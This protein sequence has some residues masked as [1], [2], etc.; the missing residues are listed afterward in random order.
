MHLNKRDLGDPRTQ[1]VL[2]LLYEHTGNMVFRITLGQV[3]G[4]ASCWADFGDYLI[5]S[6]RRWE[7]SLFGLKQAPV[8]K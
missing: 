5:H 1:C 6:R 2:I 8:Y 4:Q 7:I 3:R